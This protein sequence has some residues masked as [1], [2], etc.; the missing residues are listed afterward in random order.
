MKKINYNSFTWKKVKDAHEMYLGEEY[1]GKVYNIGM[2]KIELKDGSSPLDFYNITR[3]KDNMIK[4]ILAERN[5]T[6]D[7]LK[8]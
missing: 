1:V 4:L 2:F 3:A 7:T 5:N 6:E 8:T